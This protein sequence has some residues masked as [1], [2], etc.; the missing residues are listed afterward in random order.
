MKN[1]LLLAGCIC[2]GI[3]NSIAQISLPRLSPLQK[4]EQRVGLTDIN[5]EYS[6]P[7]RKGRVIFGELEK[8]GQLWRTGA[9]RSTKISFSE[10][11]SI[12]KTELAAG[13]YTLFTRPTKTDWEFYFYDDLSLW[14]VPDS[15][16]MDKIVAQIT[17]PSVKL[18]RTIETLTISIDD[19][20][21]NTAN[22]GISWENIYIAIPI[23]V[24]T[25]MVMDGI[26]DK[27]LKRNATEYHLAAYYYLERDLDLA[28][29]KDWIA[30]AILL[31]EKSDYR[32]YLQ[33]SFILEKLGDR[34]GA[35]KSAQQSLKIAKE[36]ESN[37]GIKENTKSLKKWGALD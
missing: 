33:Q 21:E 36:V 18:N 32:D 1:L 24:H 7:S 19:L 20:T 8:Y 10:K 6:R 34:K 9:N 5:I 26:I 15:L 29:A 27:E 16:E 13:T 35:I 12:G 37:Y 14:N 28:K 31:R 3:I 4:I 11:V 17:V 30:K 25:N 23:T 22:L 2:I